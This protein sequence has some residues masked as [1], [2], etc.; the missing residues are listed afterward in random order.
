MG[1]DDL[2]SAE[3]RLLDTGTLVRFRILD[4]H[5]EVAPDRESLCVRVD[6]VLE[7]DEHDVEPEEIVE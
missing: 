1:N 4:T 3:Q 6:L 7:D 5:T 2:Q